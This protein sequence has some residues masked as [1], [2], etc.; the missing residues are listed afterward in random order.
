MGNTELMPAY[1]AKCPSCSKQEGLPTG[2][3]VGAA[4]GVVVV[5]LRCR[6]CHAQW[7]EQLPKAGPAKVN[8]DRRPPLERD[9]RQRSILKR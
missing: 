5:D 3:T 6:A 8:G 9:G 2:A 1:P 4:H 7:T